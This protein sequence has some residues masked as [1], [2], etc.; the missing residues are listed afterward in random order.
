MFDLS[1][2]T[3]IYSF[4]TFVFVS[5]D[6]FSDCEA[7]GINSSFCKAT[8]T[9]VRGE[10][11]DSFKEYS[12]ERLI[13]EGFLT[14]FHK[15]GCVG[16]FDHFGHCKGVLSFRTHSCEDLVQS[17]GHKFIIC[18]A[19]KFG[20]LG[21]NCQ[22]LEIKT[23]QHMGIKQPEIAGICVGVNSSLNTQLTESTLILDQLQ[24]DIKDASEILYRENYV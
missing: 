7:A 10:S 17:D 5:S 3:W 19:I 15:D 24:L 23:T 13:C 11:C 12:A 2:K 21:G 8:I 22:S 18:N 14:G 1:Y 16:S 9:A 6:L 4:L 20:S